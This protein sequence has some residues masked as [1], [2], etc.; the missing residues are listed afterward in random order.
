MFQ[1]A[2]HVY[3]RIVDAGRS[4]G[5]QHA[6]YYTLRQLR[7]EKFYVYWGMDIDLTTTPTECGRLFRVN[8]DKEGGFIG[9][10]A[11]L[12]ERDAGVKRRYVQLL[13]DSN[14]HD[15]NADPWPQ[16]GEPI[17]R[18]K[19]FCGLTTSS[20]YGFTLGCQVRSFCSQSFRTVDFFF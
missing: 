18:N 15:L 9:R 8:F 3:E 20:A 2:Q 4:F 1:F 5:L 17:Y 16:G 11:L 10:E 13:V 12:K 7:I 14:A 19:K 6:G